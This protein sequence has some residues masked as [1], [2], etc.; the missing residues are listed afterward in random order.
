M[1]EGVLIIV[2]GNVT[3]VVLETLIVDEEI[4]GVFEGVVP[5]PLVNFL[6]LVIEDGRFVDVVVSIAV[7]GDEEEGM[8]DRLCVV[9]EEIEIVDNEVTR[10][11]ETVKSGGVETCFVIVT[12]VVVSVLDVSLMRDVGLEAVGE[13][14]V[15]AVGVELILEVNE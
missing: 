3:N 6:E 13:V 9:V 7:E 10:V 12:T 5:E 8:I 15:K 1:D 2:D 4:E 11:V 14:L